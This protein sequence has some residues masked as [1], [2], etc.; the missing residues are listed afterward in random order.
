[1]KEN[2]SSE[3][4]RVVTHLATDRSLIGSLNSNVKIASWAVDTENNRFVDPRT[5]VLSIPLRFPTDHF[6]EEG[7]PEAQ[8]LIRARITEFRDMTKKDLQTII[9]KKNAMLEQRN[10]GTKAAKKI[11]DEI[12]EIRKVQYRINRLIKRGE[13]AR[14]KYGDWVYVIQSP[15]LSNIQL[16]TVNDLYHNNKHYTKTTDLIKLDVGFPYN[17]M[18]FV[19]GKSNTIGKHF[20]TLSDKKHYNLDTFVNSS[21]MASDLETTEWQ[22]LIYSPEDKLKST[23]ELIK[24]YKLAENE[25]NLTELMENTKSQILE[26]VRKKKDSVREEQ[27]VIGTIAYA[28]NPLKF[29]QEKDLSQLKTFL[30]TD[31]PVEDSLDVDIPLIGGTINPEIYKV[32]N[33]EEIMKVMSDITQEYNPFSMTGHFYFKFDN[34]K[35]GELG[36]EYN[37]GID[38]E[39]PEYQWGLLNKFV[40]IRIARGRLDLDPALYYQHYAPWTVNNKLDT[41]F[42]DLTGVFEKKEMTHTELEERIQTILKGGISEKEKLEFGRLL[43]KYAVRDSIKSLINGVILLPEVAALSMLYRT[44]FHRVCSTD[45]KRLSEEYWNKRSL[46]DT[47]TFRYEHPRNEKLT[48]SFQLSK[49]YKKAKSGFIEW[50]DFKISDW[51]ERILKHY[52]NFGNYKKGFQKARLIYLHPHVKALK[53]FFAD[54]ENAMRI[55]NLNF[56]DRKSR[57]RMYKGLEAIVEYP[58][59]KLLDLSTQKLYN[60]MTNNGHPDLEEKFSREFGLDLTES[61]IR[62]YHN[63]IVRY[64]RNIGKGLKNEEVLNTYKNFILVKESDTIDDFCNRIEEFN[65]GTVMGKMDAISIGNHKFGGVIDGQM[66]NFGFSDPKSNKG[67]KN[68]AAKEILQLVMDKVLRE[69]D[70]ASALKAVRDISWGIQ[71]SMIEEDALQYKI[72][73]KRNFSEY[74]S[75]A[76]LWAKD[77][78]VKRRIK[79]GE[80]MIYHADTNELLADM[81]GIAVDFSSGQPMYFSTDN[82][83]NMLEKDFEDEL[84]DNYKMKKKGKIR[85]LVE[86]VVPTTLKQYPILFEEMSDMEFDYDEQIREQ[87]VM[88]RVICG[89]ATDEHIDMLVKLYKKISLNY[90][91]PKKQPKQ[92][93]ENPAQITIGF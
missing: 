27:I 47:L 55:F 62:K 59:F 76:T 66:M 56:D 39:K 60:Y 84:E 12:K 4:I 25:E 86:C 87:Q 19:D 89:V 45:K 71:N 44:P 85:E 3:E 31:M 23:L 6:K 65:F 30:I 15:H 48:M 93:I 17:E 68:E 29:W 69:K 74:S 70:Y 11:E 57:I 58:L 92:K 49:T 75:A 83:K 82:G 21:M 79:K 38:G 34:G 80:I 73:A 5:D 78:Y 43:H 8:D 63:D 54:D 28:E 40:Q 24:E 52:G 7:R 16:T 90:E 22:K 13:T 37:T 42:E 1:M 67:K 10:P 33:H 26:L 2:N 14:N 53:D 9:D 41:V 91:P 35:P 72:E 61:N 64:F 32:S 18:L 77:E 36:L 50:E 88:N 81:L 20:A 46:E 51:H